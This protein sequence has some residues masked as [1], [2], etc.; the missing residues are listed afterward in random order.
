MGEG[1]GENT[2]WIF[3]GEAAELG[4]PSV[5]CVCKLICAQH[6]KSTKTEMVDNM[7]RTADFLWHIEVSLT[8]KSG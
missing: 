5:W 2:D 7:I 4:A 1:D 6:T 3:E 8:S